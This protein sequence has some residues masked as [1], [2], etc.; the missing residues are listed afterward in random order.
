MKPVIL[1]SIS[2]SRGALLSATGLAFTAASPGVDETPIKLRMGAEGANGR[3][4][5]LALAEAKA[6]AISRVTPGL[7][8]GA[9]QTL[10][11]DGQLCDKTET[12]QETRDRLKQLRGRSHHLFAAVALAEDDRIL[13]RTVEQATLTMRWFSDDFLED[14]LVR[15][16]PA[17]MS[18]VGAYH[19]EG[20]GAQLFDRVDGDYFAVLGLP[21]MK[22]LAALRAAGGALE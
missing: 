17:V 21:I 18:S 7:V 1:A 3:D 16:G 11:V 22:L 10:D 20:L 5:A 14:Y 19:L 6:L 4:I 8:I 15:T 13:W 9:D 12:L 2:P